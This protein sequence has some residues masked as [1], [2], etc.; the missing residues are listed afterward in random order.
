MLA[1]VGNVV[2]SLYAKV[3]HH[4]LFPFG[5]L[6]NKLLDDKNSI[7]HTYS[8]T[9]AIHFDTRSRLWVGHLLPLPGLSAPYSWDCWDALRLRNRLD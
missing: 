7:I 1:Q 2:D 8:D 5:H 6:T 3:T 9:T 4:A